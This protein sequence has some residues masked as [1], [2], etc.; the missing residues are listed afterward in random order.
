MKIFYLTLISALFISCIGAY[1]SILGLSMIFPGSQYSVIVM[2]VALEV[3]KIVTV[4]WL[5]KNWLKSKLLM[6]L[7][8]CFAVFV[9][10]GITSLGIFGFL[11]KSH[12]EH[13][14]KASN[15]ITKIEQIETS[16]N[17]EKKFLVQYEEHIESL[18]KSKKYKDED[19]QKE[20][21]R[22][23]KRLNELQKKL[24]FDIKSEQER[25][26]KL[27]DRLTYLDEEV[28]ITEKNNSGFF[29]DK[30]KALERVDLKQKEERLK[31]N[32]DIESHKNNVNLFREE[33]KKESDKI[34]LFIDSVRSEKNII[35]NQEKIE[36]YNQKIKES[37]EIVS[38]LEKEKS[39]LGEVIRSVESEIGPLK[40]FIG[41]I[42][43][44]GIASISKDQAVRLIILIIMVV[45]DPLAI[46]LVIAAQISFYNE[47]EKINITYDKLNKKIKKPHISIT[48]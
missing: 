33:Y 23:T 1:F 4:L 42:N 44:L 20:I 11:S 45:F 46:I 38:K 27:T 5:H 6:K 18:R 26:D 22:S 13:Q 31:I 48:S 43:D 36:E 14:N 29:S 21:E 32:K 39:E 3:A 35:D 2:G 41:M 30:K 7:Y 37:I 17:A 25:I 24:E 19:K 47:K 15:E 10:M 16:I 28:K 34:K 9:L 8:F 40:Y 12:V